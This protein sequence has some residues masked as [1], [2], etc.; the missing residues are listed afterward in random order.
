MFDSTDQ[1]QYWAK[2]GEGRVGTKRLVGRREERAT[3]KAWKGSGRNMSKVTGSTYII[4]NTAGV[5]RTVVVL[6]VAD[7][8]FLV[9]RKTGSSNSR[10]T[11]E[12]GDEEEARAHHAKA[13]KQMQGLDFGKRF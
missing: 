9:E 3:R 7:V 1:G 4:G 5:T 11:Q 12:S 13:K 2:H 10:D 6:Q 8:G